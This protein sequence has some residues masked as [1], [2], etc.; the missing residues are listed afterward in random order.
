MRLVN[1]ISEHIAFCLHLYSNIRCARPLLGH[2][3]STVTSVLSRSFNSKKGAQFIHVY[4]L[5]ERGSRFWVRRLSILCCD[6]VFRRNIPHCR[7]F[8]WAEVFSISSARYM[9]FFFNQIA[10]TVIWCVLGMY[11]LLDAY[12][13]SHCSFSVSQVLCTNWLFLLSYS[14]LVTRLRFS[15]RRW[16]QDS[17]AK[18][19]TTILSLRQSLQDLSVERFIDVIDRMG[20]VSTAHANSP[21]V[22]RDFGRRTLYSFQFWNS[23]LPFWFLYFSPR[24]RDRVLRDFRWFIR[25]LSSVVKSAALKK[26]SYPQVPGS[27][28]AKKHVNSD[29]H[30]FEQIDPQ[31]RVLNYCFQ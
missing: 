24:G 2:I 27:I 21:V 3:R 25:H 19:P 9:S 17:P 12:E 8:Q 16:G 28:P 23:A 11:A 30:G 4:H 22:M 13:K 6:E 5:G 15:S 20:A 1:N 7:A 26:S 29:S 18:A 10:I 14:W 31:A